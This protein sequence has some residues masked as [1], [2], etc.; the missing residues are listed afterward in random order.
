MS[1]TVLEIAEFLGC[2]FLGD[3]T[4]SITRVSSW[5]NADI[6][7]L[8]FIES[9]RAGAALAG[10]SRAG[11]VIAQPESAPDNCRAAI[12]SAHP[13]LDFARAA[14]FIHPRP[15]AAGVKHKTAVI[16]PDAQVAEDCDIGPY[17]VIGAGSKIGPGCILHAGVVIGEDCVLESECVLHPHVVLYPGSMLGN[18]VVLHAGVVIGSDG[19]GYVFDGS[20]HVKFPQVDRIFIGDD[21]EVGANTAIDRG[22]LDATRIGAGTRIDNL[23]QIAHNVQI[24]KGVIIAAQTGISGSTVIEDYVVLGG[25]VGVADHVRIQRGAV[26][27][28]KGG[29]LPHKIVRSGDVYWGIPVRPL[30]EFKRI[31]AIFGRLP[32]MKADVDALKAAVAGLQRALE[33][34]EVPPAE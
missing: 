15:R 30:R 20:T 21:V 11:C 2:T 17:V 23:V 12:L 26:V 13:K 10:Q 29:V 34:R 18:R 3:G 33:D 24:G 27:G 8:I 28:A 4:T 31:N 14:A 9:G 6:S 22:A 7:S 19:F 5:E 16:A 1:R 32:E 25:Q